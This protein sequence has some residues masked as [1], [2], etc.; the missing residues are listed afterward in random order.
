MEFMSYFEK[1]QCLQKTLYTAPIMLRKNLTA[2]LGYGENEYRQF[3]YTREKDCI[4]SS[5]HDNDTDKR[6]IILYGFRIVF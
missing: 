3:Y 1:A 2:L 6:Q 5:L 4:G